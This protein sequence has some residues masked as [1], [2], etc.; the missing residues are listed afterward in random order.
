MFYVYQHKNPNTNEV[1]YVGKGSK[2][3][4][5]AKHNRNQYWQ[6]KVNVYGGFCVD[7]LVNNIDEE[8]AFLVEVEAIDLYKRIGCKLA[9]IT[10]G[11]DGIGGFK[12]STE[13]KQK[14]AKKAQ[15]RPGKF[16]KDHVTDKMREAVAES[17]K[18][19]LPTQAMKERKAFLGK[20]HTEEHKEYIS[21]KLKGRVFSEET[22]KK[23][24]EAQQKRFAKNPISNETKEK[25]RKAHLKDK[26]A[27]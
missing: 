17:N 11:G 16:T 24:R 4:A 8:L 22:K 13:T 25:M 10:I 12:H 14:I 15:G 19:R 9:N 6:N 7:F 3:R 20:H 18:R 27:C 23:M 2:K 1:F 5:F 26:N 21:K